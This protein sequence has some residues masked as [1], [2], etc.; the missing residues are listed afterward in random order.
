MSSC[1]G[2]TRTLPSECAA[3]RSG[4]PRYA[5][6]PALT[7]TFQTRLFLTSCYVAASIPHFVPFEMRAIDTL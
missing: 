6:R 5:P 7:Q 2:N 4:P 3:V 1:I